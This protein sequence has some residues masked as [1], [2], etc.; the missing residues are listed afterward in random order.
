MPGVRTRYRECEVEVLMGDLT[1]MDVEAIV[2]PANSLG[3]MGGGVALAIRRKG[4]REIEEE[5]RA[6]APIPVGSAVLTTGGRLRARH[7]IHAPT[8]AM[9]AERIGTENVALA[10]RAALECAREHGIKTIAFPG[11]GTGVGGVPEGEAAVAMVMEMKL[12]LEENRLGRIVLVGY[13]ESMHRAFGEALSFIFP[14][15]GEEEED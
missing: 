14:P 2:N 7:V 12:F 9:P 11:M 6:K 3:V 5:A 13:G 15:A 8:M 4:G 1:E 10:T